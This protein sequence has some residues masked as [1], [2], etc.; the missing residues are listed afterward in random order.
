[1]CL[2]APG[3]STLSPFGVCLPR[4]HTHTHGCPQPNFDSGLRAA[5]RAPRGAVPMDLCPAHSE[6]A[7]TFF[8]VI[9]FPEPAAFAWHS[10][11]HY[12]RLAGRP[13]PTARPRPASAP[14]SRVGR[15]LVSRFSESPEKLIPARGSG[16]GGSL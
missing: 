6:K 3:R 14:Q 16:V 8:V 10:F 12:T 15:K 13:L 11:S 2:S 1:M 7:P 4:T 5:S 9:N